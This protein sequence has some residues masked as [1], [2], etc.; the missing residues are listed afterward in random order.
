MVTIKEIAAQSGF[1]PSTVSYALRDNPRIPVETRDKI[2]EAAQ[3]LGYQRDARLGQLMAHLKNRHKSASTC[4]I[5]WLNSAPNPGHW[6]ETLWAKEFFESASNRAG[7]L[8]FSIS[9]LWVHDQKLPHSRLDEVLK[10]RG[11]QG[12]ILSTPLRNQ[13]WTQWID[14]DSYATVVIDD[15]FALP[16]FDRVYANYAANMR[17]VIEKVLARGY[18]RPRLWLTDYEDY[19]TGYGYTYE[20]LRQSRIHPELD[21]ILTPM[22][23]EITKESVA[24]W[25]ETNKPDV[26]IAPTAT[27][28]TRLLELGLRIPEDVGYA[29]MY[30]LNSDSKWSGVSQL[31]ATQSAVAVDRLAT[32]LQTNQVGRQARPLHIQIRGEWHE[33]TTLRP[34]MY[35]SAHSDR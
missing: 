33:G 12:L 34:P 4:P 2:K 3:K 18:K 25:M 11:T 21:P 17:A 6:H 14:W 31:H 35:H 29:A 24:A 28:G 10:A 32:L 19:W 20:C 15:P 30:V 9:E 8:G 5:A 7:E 27:F 26:V 13:D 22:G 16:Q 23:A 1:S